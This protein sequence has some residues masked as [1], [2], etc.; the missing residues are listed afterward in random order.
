MTLK[1]NWRQKTKSLTSG[2][3]DIL[4]LNLEWVGFYVLVY[5]EWT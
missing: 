2:P 3:I 1:K 5:F 4:D